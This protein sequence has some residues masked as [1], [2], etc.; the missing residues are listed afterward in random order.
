LADDSE[1]EEFGHFLM[2]NDSKQQA[3][4]HSPYPLFAKASVN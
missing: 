1:T 2:Q 3:L 4:S